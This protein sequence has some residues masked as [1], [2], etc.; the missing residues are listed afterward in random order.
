M[1]A[2]VFVGGPALD[3]MLADAGMTRTDWNRLAA[4]GAVPP[5]TYPYPRNARWRRKD[6]V[7]A[8]AR[9]AQHNPEQ[10]NA[11]HAHA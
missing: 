4:A 2:T 3:A 10:E 1:T 9:H 6:V 8:I 7:A 11:D 5:A